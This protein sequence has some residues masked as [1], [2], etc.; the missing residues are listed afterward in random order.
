MSKQGSESGG[1]W[2]DNGMPLPGESGVETGFGGFPGGGFTGGGLGS[3]ETILLAQN[4][5]TGQSD[6]TQSPG[7]SPPPAETNDGSSSGGAAETLLAKPPPGTVLEVD[8]VSGEE[9]KIDANDSDVLEIKIVDGQVHVSF[10]D[11]AVL[12]LQQPGGSNSNIPPIQSVTLLDKVATFSADAPYVNDTSTPQTTPTT[13]TTP[14]TPTSTTVEPEENTDEP[15]EE[16]TTTDSTVDPPDLTTPTT[17]TTTT[18]S[19]PSNTDSNMVGNLVSQSNEAPL[20]TLSSDDL[21][22]PENTSFTLREIQVEDSDGDNLTVTLSSSGGEALSLTDS[23]AASITL[24][25]GNGS[26]GE[27]SLSGSATDLNTVLAAGVEV[28]MGTED[29]T[30]LVGIVDD[31]SNA[32]SDQDSLVVTVN[33]APQIDLAT[34][35]EMAEFYSVTL[36]DL[37]VADAN[38]DELTVVLT[39][40]GGDGLAFVNVDAASVD[41]LDVDGSD[42]SLSISGS[43]ADLNTVLAAGVRVSA[44]EVDFSLT[45]TATDDGVGNLTSSNSMAFTVNNAPINTVPD[46][47]ESEGNIPTV[48]TDL[49]VADID[50]DTLTLVLATSNNE[51]LAFLDMTAG[52]VTGI[53]TDGSDGSLSISGSVDDLNGV[54]AAG[55]E[56]TPGVVAFILTMTTTDD[57]QNS[58][59]DVD[60]VAFTVEVNNAPVNTVPSSQEVVENNTTILTNLSVADEDGDA[61]TLVL[62]TSNSEA[63]ALTNINAG[64]VTGIDTDGSD[65][66]LSISGAVEELNAVLAAGLEITSGVDDFILTVTTTDDGEGY[67]ED[68]DSIAFTVLAND[69]PVNTLSSPQEMAENSTTTLSDLRV[70]DTDGD[71]LTLVLATSNHEALAFSNLNAGQVTGV[72]TDGSDGSLTIIG[73]G[74]EINAVLAAGLEITSG[75]GDFSLTVVTTDD[76]PGTLSDNDTVAFGVNNAPVNTLPGGQSVAENSTTTISNISVTDPNADGDL[77]TLVFSTSNNETIAFADIS[78]GNITGTDTDGSDGSLT[79]SGSTDELNAL[80]A[81]GLEVTSGIDDFTLNM[82]TTDDGAGALSESGSVDFSVNNAPV[83]TVPGTQTVDEN[84]TTTL[85]DISVSDADGGALTLVISTSN[86]QAIAFTNVNAARRVVKIDVD[87]SDGTLSLRA[88]ANGLN[89]ILAAGLEI[90]SGDEDFTLTVTTTDGGTGALVD[91]DTIAFEVGSNSAPVHSVPDAQEVI[92]GSTTTLSNLAVTDPDGDTLTLTL[93]TSNGEAMAFADVTAGDITATDVDGSDGSLTISGSAEEINSV[94]AAG[95]EV[96]AGTEEFTLTVTTTDDGTGTLS[97]SDTV[98]FDVNNAPVLENATLAVDEDAANGDLVGSPVTGSDVDGDA[99]TYTITGGN[100]DGIFTI[101]A[102]TGQITIA[103]NSNLDYSTTSQ[104]LLTVE[105]SDGT[106]TDTATVSVD[107]GN[108]NNAP[109]LE[110]TNLAVDENAANGDLVGSPVTGSDV[111]GD[112]LTYTITGGNGDGIFTID[113]DTGQITIADN[114]NLDYS[115]T[116]QYLLTVEASDGTATDTATVSV[117]IGN[118]NTA[119]VYE[120][121][122]LSVR[123]S[124]SDG[125]AVGSPVTATD[126]DGDT[127]TYSITAGNDDAIF[128]ID[129]SSGQ[130]TIAD[131]NH[132]DYEDERSHTLTVEASDGTAT[133]TATVTIGVTN[134]NDNTPSISD[135][136]LSVDEDAA[137]GD[138]VG[139]PVTGSDADGNSLSYSITSGNTDAIFTIDSSS[140]QISIDDNTNLDYS[141]TDQYTLT[142][143]ASDGSRSD[144]ATVT[145]DIGDVTSV[146]LDVDDNAPAEAGGVATVT[147]TLDA[148]SAQDVTVTLALSGTATGNGTDY[149]ASG[150][151][152]VISAGDTT[153]TITLTGEDDA[154]DEAGE[155]IIVDIDSVTNAS[156]SGTQQVTAT[157]ADDDDPPNVTLSLD[158]NAPA[159]AG[160]VSTVTATLD[161]ASGRDVTVN[162]AFSGTATDGGA[163]Y[164]ASGASIVIAAGETTGTITLTGVDDALDEAGETAIVDIDS[165]TNGTEDGSQQVTA[166]IADDDDAPNVTLSIDDTTPDEAGGVATVTA[167]LDAAS[168]RDVTVNLA[169]SGTATDGGTDY[170]ASGAAIVIAAGDTTGTVT[171]TGVDDALDEVGE[172]AIVDISSV[173]NGTEDGSQQVTATITDDDDPPNVTLS[174]DDNAPAE[175]GGV[176]TVTATLDAA[177]SQDVT[178]NLAFSG[179]ATDSGTD[180]T[181]SGAAIVIAAGDTTGTITLTGVDDALVEGDET[182]IVDISSV[183]NGTEDGTQQVTATIADDDS[184]D[185]TLSIDDTTPN[186]AGGVATVTATLSEA[187]PQDVTVTLALSGTATGSG[188]DYTASETSIVISAGDTTGTI[189]L[190]GVDDVLDEAGETAIVDIDS[191]INANEDGAQQVTAT[192]ADDDDAPSVTLSIDDTTPAEA[193]GVATVTA[194]LDAASGRDVT[195]NLAFSGTAT[196]SGTDYTAS[197][198]SIVIAAGDTTGTITLTGVDDALDEAGE[199]AVVDISSVTNGTE[200]GSQQV[201]A[202]YADDDDAPSVTLSIDDTTP[203]E[204]GG[205]ATVTATL[206]AA[207]GRDVTVNLTFSGTATDSGTDYTASG[208]SIVIAA[209]DTTGTITLTGVDDTLDEVGETAIVDINS[210]TNGTEDGSQQVTA[211]YADDD[212]PPNVSLSIDDNAPAEGG[213]VATVTA[214]L[215]AASS[216]DVTVAL[217]LSGTAT[218][219][220]TDYT[221]SA[222][223]IVIAAGDTTGTITLT[224]VNDALDE[225]GETVIVDIDS[226]TNGAEDGSQQVTATIADDDDAP[227]VTLSI[228]DTT[229]AEAGG[230]ATVTATLDAASG[231]DVTVN[232]AF[233][234]TATDSGTDYTASGASIVIAAGDTT[235]TITLTGVDDTLDET[236]ETAIVDISSV[237]NGTEDGSQQVTATLADDDDPPDVTLSI[238]DTTPGEAGGVA[239]VTATLA[240]ASGQDVTVNLALSG[241]ATDG[242]T[243]YTASAASIVIAAGDTT[244]TITLTGVDDTLDEAGETAIVDISSVVNGNEATAQQVTATFADDDDPPEVTLSIDDDTPTEAGTDVATVTATLD[245]ASSYDV[246]VDLAISGTATDTTDY[247][248]S[249]TSIT[250]AA[251]DTTGTITLTVVDDDDDDNDETIIVDIDGDPT[252][253]TEGTPNQVTA[254]ITDDDDAGGSTITVTADNTFTG[255]FSDGVVDTVVWDGIFSVDLSDFNKDEDIIDLLNSTFTGQGAVT[256]TVATYDGIIFQNGTTMNGATPVPLGFWY[257]T[258]FVPNQST[259]AILLTLA[260]STTLATGLPNDLTVN[261]FVYQ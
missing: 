104:Y 108:I 234:G 62:T 254:T 126:V 240:A 220:G 40:D 123:E 54:L 258:S 188:T 230:V 57:G 219:S 189:T 107:I 73:S 112:A 168:G 24:V 200:D 53:D 35:R 248:A 132:L 68:V 67:L 226:V 136:T 66:S 46:A 119:P 99:L 170:T 169:L 181:A 115:T 125:D 124:A 247:T 72:D 187:S 7:D 238:D 223:S 158:D 261:D 154:L 155:T 17:T 122:T 44:G 253:G 180:Y 118:I 85:T 208:A 129:E 91:S 194:T 22:A 244:G 256:G 255:T 140:G 92:A 251:G 45:M 141:T 3:G 138:L 235:G 201:T 209:G 87:G 6:E 225:A 47:R 165:V 21:T 63:L 199:T 145:V 82:T 31:A 217:S 149:T 5:P 48:L 134:V 147:A 102:D 221:A 128:A 49:R 89:S 13:T 161:A 51:A 243:D 210:V 215:D 192:F 84:S 18:T 242:G 41:A 58:L 79:V 153:G 23:D 133:D 211:T 198:A 163:D 55:V 259:L 77:L 111:D 146:T 121:A 1:L 241:T 100:G 19:P 114:S 144:T 97:D 8:V 39:S 15:Q 186:E 113:A 96:T 52:S 257:G 174:L 203:A 71:T 93:S 26:D 131:N 228:D 237:T 173:V 137:D 2:L 94:L 61:L 231:R 252:N 214:T 151:S 56:V 69:A 178:V 260:S 196:D 78:A 109:V 212:D 33:N 152:I 65:G 20:I 9:V 207:S 249:G 12:I 103:D 193:G 236:G 229:P 162:L 120:D 83:N 88:T 76:G 37:S 190:T 42:G 150:T 105:A 74:D 80:L 172:T 75:S 160:G 143:E 164:S 148:V 177:S 25:D 239:T 4:E 116:S 28:A 245:A 218:G 43:V 195:V 70:A 30:L 206:D 127:L 216:Q 184:P 167:T 156:E 60:T 159:E 227:S 11:G 232:L 101:E 117:D 36:N 106:A 16:E 64:T 176:A 34:P 38:G 29:L 166:T 142:V 183:T 191:V 14:S 197:G 250:I 32:G 130:I 175:A 50:G 202:T 110:D 224:G 233:S 182:A 86:G 10:V 246:T 157:I 59:A 95:V 204:A 139:S 90:S 179:T 135:A 205:V 213:G 171:L 27:I 222:T 185:V 81:A 98:A